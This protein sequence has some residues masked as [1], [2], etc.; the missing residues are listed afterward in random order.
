MVLTVPTTKCLRYVVEGTFKAETSCEDTV[1]AW[2]SVDEA[3][4]L[5]RGI[6]LPEESA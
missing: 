4:Q 6:A 1:L 2:Q 5:W 3:R